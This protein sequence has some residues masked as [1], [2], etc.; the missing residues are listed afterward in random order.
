MIEII[1]AADIIGGRCVRLTQGSFDS[2]K[3]YDSE[4]LKMAEKYRNAG[5][6][7][8][9]LVDLDGARTGNLKNTAVLQ[10]IAMNTD[11][12]I[13]C[14]GGIKTLGDVE[15]LFS[16]GAYAVN[17]GSAAVNSPE[18]MKSCLQRY[19]GDKIILSA[20]VDGENIKI[21][22]W[23]DDAGLSLFQLIESFI[24]FGLKKICVTAIRCDGMLQGPDLVLYKKIKEKYPDLYLIA[25]GGVGDIQDIENLNEI[26]ADAV[27]IGK[28]IYENKISLQQLAKFVQ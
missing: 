9:H 26:N 28:A 4:P 8:L 23:Q 14:G 11:L 13:D 22:G 2:V 19:G 12:K 1:P 3:K 18:M 27:I 25:S 7:N 15:M 5:L 17:L 10:E 24:P 21:R 20:D 16:L 6:K